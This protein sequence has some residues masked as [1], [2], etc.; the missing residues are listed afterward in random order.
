VVYT[1]IDKQV[2]VKYNSL[3]CNCKLYVHVSD[4]IDHHYLAM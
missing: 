1:L 4:L 2:T 3:L